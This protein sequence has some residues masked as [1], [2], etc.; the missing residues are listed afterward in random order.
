ML[1]F[2]IQV[3]PLDP[4][5]YYKQLLVWTGFHSCGVFPNQ[6][7]TK[8]EANKEIL[9]QNAKLI[10]TTPDSVHVQGMLVLESI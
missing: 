10:F 1:A 2:N 8:V 3:C 5:I 7:M 6:L 9:L 4:D